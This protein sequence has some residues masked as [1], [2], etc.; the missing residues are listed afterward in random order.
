MKGRHVSLGIAEPTLP[1]GL[2]FEF[3]M[4]WAPSW[5]REESIKKGKGGKNALVKIEATDKIEDG[6]S[7]TIPDAA[8][9]SRL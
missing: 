1:W 7:D 3:W 6:N 2:R 5:G 8:E 4:V 9:K